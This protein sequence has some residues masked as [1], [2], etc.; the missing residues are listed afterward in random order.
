MPHNFYVCVAFFETA[1]IPQ[2]CSLDPSLLIRDMHLH[3][4]KKTTL[5]AQTNFCLKLVTCD[6]K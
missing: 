2:N 4:K 3:M 1:G 5:S 6:S